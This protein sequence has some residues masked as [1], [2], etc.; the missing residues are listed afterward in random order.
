VKITGAPQLTPKAGALERPSIRAYVTWA[1]WSD[2]FI[3]L[4]A[5]LTYG[6]TNRGWAVGVQLETW[7]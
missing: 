1:G 7:W 3:G 4:V 6:D 2:D 5:P